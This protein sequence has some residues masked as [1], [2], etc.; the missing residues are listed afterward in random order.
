[1]GPGSRPEPHGG[2]QPAEPGAAATRGRSPCGGGQGSQGLLQTLLGTRPSF[3]EEHSM[4]KLERWPSRLDLST[5]TGASPLLPAPLLPAPLSGSVRFQLPVPESCWGRGWGHWW[6]PSGSPPLGHL[7]QG[8]RPISVPRMPVDAPSGP[9][10]L[11]SSAPCSYPGTGPVPSP[12]VLCPCRWLGYLGLLL[13]G[14]A[15]CLLVLVGL[16]RSSRGS[17]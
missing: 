10:L 14:V 1:M 15:I 17:W 16:I 3:L 11:P 13:L 2:A 7:L 12:G 4:A 8:Q 9:G 6:S 5:G